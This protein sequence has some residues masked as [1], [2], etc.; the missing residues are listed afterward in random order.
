MRSLGLPVLLIWFSFFA[1]TVFGH[2]GMKYAVRSTS[3]QRIVD[4]L[5]AVFGPWGLA[6]LASW[7]ISALLW[8]LILAKQPLFEASSISAFRY[9]LIIAASWVILHENVTLPQTAGVFL[10]FFGIFLVVR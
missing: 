1:S 7:I 9:I 4:T 6:A 2:I 10:I 5:G 3:D 8:A